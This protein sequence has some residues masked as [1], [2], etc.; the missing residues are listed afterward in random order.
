MI[1]TTSFYDM[2]HKMLTKNKQT[3]TVFPKFQFIPILSV[4]VMRAYV[5]LLHIDYCVKLI[6]DNENLCKNCSYFT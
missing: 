1:L 4:Q 6:L 2:N 5:A 3:K